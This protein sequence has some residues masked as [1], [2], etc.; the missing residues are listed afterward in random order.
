MF[1]FGVAWLALLAVELLLAYELLKAQL[2][3]H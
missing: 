2:R 1:I 3:N